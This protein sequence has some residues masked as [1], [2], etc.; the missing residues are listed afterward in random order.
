MLAVESFHAVE[1]IAADV[2]ASDH[3]GRVINDQVCGGQDVDTFREFAIRR[4]VARAIPGEKL[5]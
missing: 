4:Q 1:P 5:F 3:R 2:V